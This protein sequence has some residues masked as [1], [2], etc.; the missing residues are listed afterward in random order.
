VEEIFRFLTGD[1]ESETKG[2]LHCDNKGA[3]I[4]PRAGEEGLE[5]LPRK[6]RHIAI[7]Y[8]RVLPEG[9]RVLFVPTDKQRGYG[10]TKSSNSQARGQIFHNGIKLIKISEAEEFEL[11]SNDE[12][13]DHTDS[14][15]AWAYNLSR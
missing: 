9:D 12:N 3:V 6:T 5:L 11:N 14:Y 15:L 8:A 7:R 4:G 1:S 13:L 10:L 2:G